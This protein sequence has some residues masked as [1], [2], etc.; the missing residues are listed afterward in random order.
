MTFLDNFTP[1]IRF[2]YSRCEHSQSQMV[3]AERTGMRQKAR[4]IK[5]AGWILN[6][7]DFADFFLGSPDIT[8]SKSQLAAQLY[9]WSYSWEEHFVPAL[10]ICEGSAYIYEAVAS[11]KVNTF[12]HKNN[13][14]T[15]QINFDRHSPIQVLKGT[16][17]WEFFWLRFWKLRHFFV[18]NVKIL[19][20]YKKKIFDWAIIGGG[21]IFPRSPRT[22]RNEKTFWARSKN[23]F[24]SSSILDPKYDPILVFWKFNQLNA[25][26]TTLCVDLGSK[27]QIL[28]PLVWD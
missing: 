5:F 8:Y 15:M 25:P 21:T 11:G 6:N 28:F 19:R 24:F 26:G 9:W 17:D 12:L 16:Q 18:S 3:F 7:W 10:L 14:L 2:A 23:F 1:S 4:R 13:M 27:W 20:F 22:T